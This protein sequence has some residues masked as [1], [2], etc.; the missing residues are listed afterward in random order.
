MKRF[1]LLVMAIVVSTLATAQN[2]NDT[3]Q[4][5]NNYGFSHTY[6]KEYPLDTIQEGDTCYLFNPQLSIPLYIDQSSYTFWNGCHL[7]GIIEPSGVNVIPY[8]VPPRDSLLYGIAV[9]MFISDYDSLPYYGRI[10]AFHRVE[11]R[12]EPIDTL[13]FT[14]YHQV[15]AFDYVTY[16]TSG[17]AHHAYAY[18]YEFYFDHPYPIRDT[19]YVGHYYR[20]GST[21]PD[22]KSVSFVY[23]PAYTYTSLKHYRQ[24]P[25]NW[26]MEYWWDNTAVWQTYFP[27]VRPDRP[28]CSRPAAPIVER[29]EDGAA[30]IRWNPAG[31]SIRYF[32]RVVPTPSLGGNELTFMTA[33]TSIDLSNLSEGVYYTAMLRAQCDH[34]CPSHNRVWSDWSEPTTFY[35]GNQEPDTTTAIE[36]AEYAPLFSLS[37][38]PA[39]GMVL[40]KLSEETS[41]QVEILDMEG[42]TVLSLASTAQLITIDVSGLAVGVYLVHLQ[43][44]LGSAIRKLTIAR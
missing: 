8:Q 19:V 35:L 28:H 16:D 11:N 6:I 37:P 38:N 5:T 14:N 39:T 20:F 13:D 25:E 44:P 41:A 30:T 3:I 9:T 17:K 10:A 34:H 12:I 43:S 42:R 31:D 1:V 15:N 26:N 21:I 7:G 33:D 18:C 36:M 23:C 32:L 4:I 40:V 22:N 29:G 24:T 27:I 2:T